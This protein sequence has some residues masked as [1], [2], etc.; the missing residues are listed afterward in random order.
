M[1]GFHLKKVTLKRN[2]FFQGILQFLKGPPL[3]VS[4][5][6]SL[7]E[8]RFTA[9]GFYSKEVLLPSLPITFHNIV[10]FILP[11]A[12]LKPT[13]PVVNLHSGQLHHAI[14]W[15]SQND[16]PKWNIF[17]AQLLLK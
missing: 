5:I 14:T 2:L 3:M 9:F 17:N 13:T 12:G 7:A 11:Y 8:T 1:N 16:F 15:G 6:P 10:A 4:W